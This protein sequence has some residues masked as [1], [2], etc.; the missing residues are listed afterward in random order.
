MKRIGLKHK[1]RTSGS[2]WAFVLILGLPIFALYV[3]FCVMPM[4]TSVKYG[5]FT[6]DYM[7]LAKKT[8]AG[9][10][11][12][13]GIFADKT[14]WN[15]LKNDALIVLGKELIIVV[16]SIFFAVSLTRFRLKKGEVTFYQIGRAHV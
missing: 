10:G 15:A 5:F 12:Y 14:F 7:D 9:I 13:K 6:V 16:F 3:F 4:F 8:F 11:N 1:T 2:V